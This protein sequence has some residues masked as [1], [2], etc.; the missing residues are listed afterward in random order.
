MPDQAV[1]TVDVRGYATSVDRAGKG[2]PVVILSDFFGPQGW[3]P[4]MAELAQRFEVFAPRHPGIAGSPVPEWLDTAADLGNFYLDFLD[5]LALDKAHLVG[6]GVG[7]WIAAELAIRNCARLASL[8]LVAPLG[9]RVRGVPQSDIFLGA[10]DDVLRVLVHDQNIAES[11]IAETVTPENEDARL[12]N[13]QLLARVAWE[14]RLHNPHLVKWLHRISVPVHLVVGDH[15]A[16]FPEPYAQAWRS[17]IVNSSCDMIR[18]CGHL[19]QFERAR[20][21]VDCVSRFIAGR[22][23]TA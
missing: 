10:D 2:A 5:A 19:P 1:T 7:G 8:T 3:Q 11:L 16:L 13:Q 6:F 9:L 22:K 17:G 21:T 20:E 4:Y 12:Y 14:P 15:D 18:E 23:V